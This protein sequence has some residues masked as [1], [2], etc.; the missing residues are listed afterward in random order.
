MEYVI[1]F[2]GGVVA[3]VMVPK[4]FAVGAAAVAWVKDRTSSKRPDADEG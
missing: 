3:A 4:V 2:V 1:G